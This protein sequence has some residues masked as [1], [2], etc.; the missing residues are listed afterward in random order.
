MHHGPIRWDMLFDITYIADWNKI[1]DF[2]QHQT[3]QNTAHENKERVDY[4]YK[5]GGKV[6]I[7]KDGI[8]HKSELL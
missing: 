5:V 1:G 7:W 6:L 3:D 8:L 2:R 4:D